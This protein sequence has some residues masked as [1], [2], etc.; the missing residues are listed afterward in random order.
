MHLCPDATARDGIDLSYVKEASKN[1]GTTLT[2]CQKYHVVVVKSTV[3]PT[4][5]EKVVIPLLENR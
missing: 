2:L 4:T 5:T 1:I 3:V